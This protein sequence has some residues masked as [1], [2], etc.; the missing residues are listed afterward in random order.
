MNKMT[1]TTCESFKL[2][3]MGE[4][5]GC[6]Y[7]SNDRE[8]GCYC[9]HNKSDDP[10][11]KFFKNENFAGCPFGNDYSDT[12]VARVNHFLINAAIE[13]LKGSVNP[14]LN[15]INELLETEIEPSI[16]KAKTVA[17]LKKVITNLYP[18]MTNGQ[19]KKLMTILKG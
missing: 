9:S 15:L 8:F 12:L 19:T 4:F 7:F 14:I 3:T 6:P 2:G 16:N 11:S 17:N 18:E 1:I 13:E 10:Y 5:K